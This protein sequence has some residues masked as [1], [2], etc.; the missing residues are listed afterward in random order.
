MNIKVP[1]VYLELELTDQELVFVE[2]LYNLHKRY[3]GKW[4]Y[5]LHEDDLQ[6][7]LQTNYNTAKG[8]NARFNDQISF[9]KLYND[10]YLI[11]M[12]CKNPN[13]QLTAV[14]NLTDINAIKVYCYLL[15][16]INS[17]VIEGEFPAD[18]EQNTVYISDQYKKAMTP[19]QRK[20]L[21][22]KEI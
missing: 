9:V 22:A 15:G 1:A 18:K 7:I 17:G 14:H 8:L 21:D 2:I 6:S 20:Q 3:T 4:K 11:G 13:K 16:R 5:V 10:A 12:T 19:Y